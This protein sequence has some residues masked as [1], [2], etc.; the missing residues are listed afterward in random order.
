MTSLFQEVAR[1]PLPDS[2]HHPLSASKAKRWMVCPAAGNLADSGYTNDAAKFG[3]KVHEYAERLSRGLLPSDNTIDPQALNAANSYLDAINPYLSDCDEVL[4]ESRVYLDSITTMLFDPLSGT[5]DKIGV[6]DWGAL[7]VADLKTGYVDVEVEDNDQLDFYALGAYES[8]LPEVRAGITHIEEF[9]VQVNGRVGV[10]VKQVSKSV[11]DLLAWGQ[12]ASN[13][14]AA[15]EMTPDVYVAGEHCAKS[16]CPKM[17]KC[18]AHLNYMRESVGCEVTELIPEDTPE[19]FAELEKMGAALPMVKAWCK[20]VEE[21]LLN[22]C[23]EQPEMFKLFK[24]V[25]SFGHRKFTDEAAFI[26]KAREAGVADQIFDKKLKTPGQL[27]K[28]PFVK[29]ILE[30]DLF[31]RPSCGHNLK[32]L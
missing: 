22:L 4:T 23:I 5:A 28:I 20:A 15:V 3:T 19:D 2:Y 11:E 29:E 24:A 31:F 12:R 17:F 14:V 26:T 13:A 32:K 18:A 8:L 16:Y 1:K 21:R 27:E 9:I 30:P 10:E 6:T 7:K 25:A